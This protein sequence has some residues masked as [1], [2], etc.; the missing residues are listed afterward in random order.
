MDPERESVWN[1]LGVRRL[2]AGLDLTQTMPPRSFLTPPDGREKG[3]HVTLPSLPTLSLGGVGVAGA[4]PELG[5]AA[6]DLAITGVLGEGG[7]G[8]V[9][10]A[11]QRSL[12]RDVAVKV[13]K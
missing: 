10:L 8:R 9:M 1:S 13:V 5:D 6:P 11:H 3:E 12:Q 7:M 2:R 4:V